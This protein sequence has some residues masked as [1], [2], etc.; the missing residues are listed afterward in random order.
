MKT[1]ERFSIDED[2]RLFT[3]AMVETA[4]SILFVTWL[5]TSCGEAPG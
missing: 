4:S 5:S 3:F 1:C 2:W